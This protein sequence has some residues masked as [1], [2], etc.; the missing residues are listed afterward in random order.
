M[1]ESAMIESAMTEN[2][3]SEGVVIEE[4][5]MSAKDAVSN[6]ELG[7]LGQ[8]VSKKTIMHGEVNLSS[9]KR[10]VSDGYT[11]S[12]TALSNQ[13]VVFPAIQPLKASHDEQI[14]DITRRFGRAK[15]V[16]A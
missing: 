2:F 4:N 1:I 8:V 15:R 13:K 6:E 14:L 12:K 10:A 7:A 11:S 3:A 5:A 9:K 16:R